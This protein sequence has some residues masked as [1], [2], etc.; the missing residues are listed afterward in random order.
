[1]AIASTISM[2]TEFVMSSKSP[3][4][5][6][7]Q[8]VITIFLHSLMMVLAAIP[9]ARIPMPAISISQPSAM[10]VFAFS[11]VAL[12]LRHAIMIH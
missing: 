3:D 12:H 1:M 8:R 11:R 5:L 9:V 7:L 2:P 4:V 6:I 10:T